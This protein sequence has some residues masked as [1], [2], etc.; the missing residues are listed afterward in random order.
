MIVLC[1]HVILL[2]NDCCNP[3]NYNCIRAISNGCTKSNSYFLH[4][5]IMTSVS[6]H[7]CSQSLAHSDKSPSKPIMDQ[8]VVHVDHDTVWLILTLFL[9]TI[10]HYQYSI[11]REIVLHHLTV[12]NQPKQCMLEF[13]QHSLF[14][15]HQTK[16]ARTAFSRNNF[17]QREALI[18]QSSWDRTKTVQEMNDTIIEIIF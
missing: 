9:W 13:R 4:D 1:L 14:I 6:K 7:A 8:I 15:K 17:K 2:K 3:V 10:K 18:A 11:L 16:F 5:N 12:S